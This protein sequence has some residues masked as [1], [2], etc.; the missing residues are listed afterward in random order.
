MLSA[1]IRNNKPG[2]TA[3]RLGN[4]YM[5]LK[6]ALT[7]D[8]PKFQRY[9]LFMWICFFCVDDE[10]RRSQ[11]WAFHL[12]SCIHMQVH[13][14][15]VHTHIYICFCVCVH[16]HKMDGCHYYIGFISYISHHDMTWMSATMVFVFISYISL[17]AR[18][19]WMAPL[20]WFS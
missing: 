12:D 3:F 4:G 1:L 16:M 13:T 8:N 10:L 6:A 5:G 20:H 15:Y 17:H 11:N 7:S 19:G 14:L 2:V 9:R 18:D